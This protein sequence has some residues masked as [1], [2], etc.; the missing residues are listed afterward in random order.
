[1]RDDKNTEHTETYYPHLELV[2]R[3]EWCQF[4][5]KYGIKLDHTEHIHFACDVT[6]PYYERKKEDAETD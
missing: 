6:C 1:M 4:L 2:M 5:H 3:C